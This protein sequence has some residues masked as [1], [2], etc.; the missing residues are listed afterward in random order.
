MDVKPA[1][2]FFG[3]GLQ[4]KMEVL[5]EGKYLKLGEVWI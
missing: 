3:R 1:S 5:D 2:T 4:A